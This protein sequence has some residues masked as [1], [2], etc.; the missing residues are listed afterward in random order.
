MR[1]QPRVL[2][3]VAN[4]PPLRRHIRARAFEHDAVDF[5]VRFIRAQQARD[6]VRKRRLAAAR[7]T[8]QCDH[9]RRRHL[10]RNIQR[11][12]VATFFSANAEHA[13]RHLPSMSRTRRAMNSA[14]INPSSPSEK[15]TSASR[16]ATASPPGVCKAA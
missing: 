1:K 8:E 14:A 4:A 12:S 11:K 15:E 13:Q 2:K 16:A 10:D 6:D 7:A 5:H 9:A 3:D